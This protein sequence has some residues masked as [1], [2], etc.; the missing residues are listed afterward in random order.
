AALSRTKTDKKDA[1]LIARFC[2]ERRPPLWEP[3]PPPVPAELR[4][5]VMRRDALERMRTQE[6]NRLHVARAEVQQSVKRHIY[7][8][9]FLLPVFFSL[10]ASGSRLAVYF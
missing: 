5:L 6:M 2:A 7:A 10:A 9:F 4:S 3:S 1:R 8:V